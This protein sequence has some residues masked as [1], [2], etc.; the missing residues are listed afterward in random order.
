MRNQTFE[1]PKSKIS[2]SFSPVLGKRQH[3][4]SFTTEPVNTEYDRL[5]TGIGHDFGDIQGKSSQAF[6]D[7]C[8]LSLPNPSRC[9]Y[10][11]ACHSCTPT[12]QTKLKI[13]QPNDK[14]E[15]EA[16][17]ISDQVMRMPE[18]RVQ[19]KGC[20]TCNDIDEEEQIQTKPISQQI[21][22]LVQRQEVEPEEEEDEELIQTKTVGG[23]L[24]EVTPGINAG[25]QSLKG[26]GR[27]LSRSE[28]SFFEPRFGV[29]FSDVRLHT[30][31]Q[32]G[33]IAKRTNARAFTIGRDVMFGAREYSPNSNKGKQL[34]AHE[35]SHVIQQR[36]WMFRG[37]EIECQRKPVSDEIRWRIMLCVNPFYYNEKG[38]YTGSDPKPDCSDMTI[39]ADREHAWK[40][41]D[42]FYWSQDGKKW[43]WSFES[44]PNCSDLRLPVSLK[45]FR[46]AHRKRGRKR[47]Q[48][49]KG[50][51]NERK[52]VELCVNPFY[53]DDKGKYYWSLDPKPDCS[54]MT[55]PADRK[56]AWKC[57]DNFYWSQDGEKWTWSFEPEPNCSDLKIPI[58]LEKYRG[59]TPEQKK[60]REKAKRQAEIVQKNR[61]QIIAIRKKAPT[62]VDALARIFTD[63]YII[64]DNTIVGRTN[65]IIAA[66]THQFIPGLQTGIKFR[67]SGFRREF[68]DPW[69]SSIN[70][71]GHFLTAVRLGFDPD[72]TSNILFLTILNAWGDS[73]IPLRLIIGHEKEPD[74][75]ILNI[76]VGFRKQYKATTD[77]DI[78]NFKAGNLDRINV[79]TGKGNSMADLKLSYKGWLM[80]RWIAEGRFK[81]KKEIADWIRHVI[82]T[83]KK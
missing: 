69:E 15:Q 55:I 30:D 34:L 41:L 40:C 19:R 7:S 10:S 24:P 76:S 13:G 14:Y 9:S 72:F 32:A 70:Q 35:L 18:P 26:G 81:T 52:R 6:K 63:K 29:H 67:Q 53:Y 57:L 74:P 20:L 44:E 45:D 8:P 56:R 3:D 38:E 11:G 62:D 64:D 31:S 36:H 42:N 79:G 17:R 1:K 46:V 54:D 23:V 27:P 71:V 75:G 77:E 4:R 65:A 21:T 48:L 82:G 43:T 78:K 5:N 73:D 58:S 37:S 2:T 66:T 47:P 25:V 49:K 28:R 83:L 61:D 80:G 59:E 60:A 68:H 51:S 39:P 12:I 50:S 33:K 16:D 22:P